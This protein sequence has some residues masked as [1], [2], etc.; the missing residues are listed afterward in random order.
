MT[1]KRERQN[2]ILEIIQEH[3]VASQEDLRKLLLKR[4]WDV[5]QT[6]L[7]RDLRELRIGRVPTDDGVRYSILDGSSSDSSRAVL[8]ALL[9]QL[10]VAVDGVSELIV[11]RTRPGSAN[12]IAEALDAER[13]PDLIGTIAGDNTLL[14]I[15]RSSSARERMTRRLASLAARDD[16]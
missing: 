14:I 5:T 8:D 13:W 15:C 1:N 10:F 3:P 12:A 6:T 9:P 4:G 7:S 2:N 11:L 16:D